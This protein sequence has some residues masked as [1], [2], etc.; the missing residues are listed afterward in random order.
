VP[1]ARVRARFGGLE[2]EIVADAEGYFHVELHP[3]AE[4]QRGAWHAVELEL[5]DYPGIRATGQVLVPA[6][7]GLGVVSDIDDTILES[8]VARKLRML[9]T[10]ALSNSRTRKPFSGVAAFYRALV[11]RG[12]GAPIF[13]VS[14]SPWNLYAPIVE[15]M[16]LQA[17]PAGALLLRDFGLHRK[18]ADHKER[19]IGGIVRAHPERIRVIYIRSVDPAPARLAA[20]AEL[21]REVAHT[22]CQLVLCPDSEVA[23]VHAAGEGLISPAALAAVRREKNADRTAPRIPPPATRR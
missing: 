20:V 12:R 10:L 9:L 16:E 3:P 19:S 14:K 15:F 11:E 5:A 21:A 13:Y 4:L 8:N 18:S 7:T 22:G 23:A 6:Q 17:L 1:H 2:Q